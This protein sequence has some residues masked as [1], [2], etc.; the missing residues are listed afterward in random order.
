MLLKANK[1]QD[2]GNGDSDGIND[3]NDD[4]DDRKG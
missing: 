1:A 3:I 2:L 4:E